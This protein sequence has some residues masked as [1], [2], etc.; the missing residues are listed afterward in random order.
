MTHAEAQQLAKEFIATKDDTI[1]V[2]RNAIDRELIRALM[3]TAFMEG[4]L[5]GMRDCLDELK[6]TI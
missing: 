4:F 5:V 3:E 6:S 2:Y 1:K